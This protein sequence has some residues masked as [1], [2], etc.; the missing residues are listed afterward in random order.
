MNTGKVGLDIVRVGDRNLINTVH[1]EGFMGSVSRWEA[2]DIA[3]NKGQK[4]WSGTMDI[5]SE[6]NK[7]VTTAFPVQ[8]AL[9]RL[10]PGVYLMVAPR[11]GRRPVRRN[12]TRR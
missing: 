11:A 3:N 5:K 9:G 8:E 4:V 6:L 7:D 2:R 10:Q 1:G 12:A